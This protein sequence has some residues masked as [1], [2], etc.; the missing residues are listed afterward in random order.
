[1][2]TSALHTRPSTDWGDIPVVLRDK[3]WPAL[4]RTG[5]Q[6]ANYGVTLALV[7]GTFAT[8]DVR[9]RWRGRVL[10]AARALVPAAVLGLRARD[11]TWLSCCS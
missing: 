7:G 8:V 11:E 10:L 3:P 5:A 4:A 6:M 2:A 9:L 1:M